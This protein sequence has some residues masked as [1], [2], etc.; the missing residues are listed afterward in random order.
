VKFGLLSPGRARQRQCPTQDI[1][2][3]NPFDGGGNRSTRRK[4][5]VR[6]PRRKS[7]L[8]GAT[9]LVTRAGIEPTPRTDISYR[10][11]SQIRQTRHEPLGHHVPRYYPAGMIGI[12]KVQY[13]KRKSGVRAESLL[14]SRSILH[15]E[16]AEIRAGYQQSRLNPTFAY[17]P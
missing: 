17:Q 14:A 9:C 13:H 15:R 11:L 2:G 5:P 7:L 1:G 3:I 8:Y 4:P 12:Y 10:P 6:D 16:N